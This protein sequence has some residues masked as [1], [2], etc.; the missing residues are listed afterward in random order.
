MF[1]GHGDVGGDL[2]QPLHQRL[3]AIQH[4]VE[5]AGEPIKFVAHTDGGNEVFQPAIHD[6][7]KGSVHPVE[8]TKK[9]PGDQEAAADGQDRDANPAPNAH[10]RSQSESSSSSEVLR[11]TTRRDSIGK[12]NTESPNRVLS[13]R[14]FVRLRR[15]WN[16]DFAPSNL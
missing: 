9:N 14:G 5:I 4:E 3:V 6:V 11:P 7:L 10:V 12:L 2:P 1:A 8:P 13:V 16:R 15:L